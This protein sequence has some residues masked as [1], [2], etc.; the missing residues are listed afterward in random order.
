MKSY[1]VVLILSLGL[2]LFLNLP[3]VFA[4][5]DPSILPNAGLTP[6]NRLYFIDQWFESIHQFFTIRPEAKI[7]LHL[8]LIVERIAEMKVIVKNKG[9]EAPEVE[10]IKNFIQQKLDLISAIISLE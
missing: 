7:N 6:L 3:P 2:T 5:N 1:N 8:S 10:T 9:A 4:N